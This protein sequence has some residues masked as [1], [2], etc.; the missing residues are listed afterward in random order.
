MVPCL[1][2]QGLPNRSYTPKDKC[3]FNF[4]IMPYPYSVF[5]S[6]IIHGICTSSVIFQSIDYSK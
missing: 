3:A 2:K 1:N 5:I 6:L 4:K